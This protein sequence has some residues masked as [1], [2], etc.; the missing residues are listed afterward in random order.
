MSRVPAWRDGF[1]ARRWRGE[2]PLRRLFW[3]DMLAVGTV[4]NLLA[5]FT[6]LMAAATGASMTVA[7]GLHFLPLPYNVF[8][9]AALWRLPG[10][11]PAAVAVGVVWLVLMTLV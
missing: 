9:L 1:L 5:T 7:V 4:I 2:V 11:A 8:L 6:G 10:R 3:L